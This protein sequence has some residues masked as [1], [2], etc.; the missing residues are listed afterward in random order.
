MSARKLSAWICFAQGVSKVVEWRGP[1]AGGRTVV[2]VPLQERMSCTTAMVSSDVSP[3]PVFQILIYF[4]KRLSLIA[5]PG[6]SLQN[7]TAVWLEGDSS[8][9]FGLTGGAALLYGCI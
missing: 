1:E 8:F 5:Q 3:I 6:Y 4:A 2:F 9:T 7:R